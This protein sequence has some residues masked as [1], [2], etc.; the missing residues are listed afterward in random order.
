MTFL[1]SSIEEGK[2]PLTTDHR[3]EVMGADP[4]GLLAVQ[5]LALA[6]CLT[7]ALSAAFLLSCIPRA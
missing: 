1:L 5:H 6:P 4:N 7:E 3:R 2:N